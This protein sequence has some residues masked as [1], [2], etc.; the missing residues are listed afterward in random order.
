VVACVYFARA[1]FVVLVRGLCRFN[2]SVLL[3][4]LVWGGVGK[5]VLRCVLYLCVSF[6]VFFSCV[7][8]L[9]G[10]VAGALWG[11]GGGGGGGG[12]CWVGACFCLIGDPLT[13]SGDPVCAFFCW[14]CCLSV[15]GLEVVYVFLIRCFSGSLFVL[16][17]G[18]W[19]CQLS[20]VCGAC[21]GS[22][23]F[24]FFVCICMDVLVAIGCLFVS[25]FLQDVLFVLYADSCG[26]FCCFLWWSLGAHMALRLCFGTIL[27][28]VCLALCLLGCLL[29]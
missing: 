29:L 2:Y 18:V 24:L 17:L 5:C 7:S 23:V 28:S 13:G 14:E 3:L 22:L 19:Q 27:L 25:F 1:V 15:Q 6:S 16:T 9:S 8:R 12:L 26:V 20:C 21:G 4:R 10:R 11:G